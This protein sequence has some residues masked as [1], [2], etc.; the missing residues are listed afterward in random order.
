MATF[1][2]SNFRTLKQLQNTF[3]TEPDVP[4]A[5]IVVRIQVRTSISKKALLW[6]VAKSH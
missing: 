5:Y 6:K 3:K 2:F 4:M 1:D